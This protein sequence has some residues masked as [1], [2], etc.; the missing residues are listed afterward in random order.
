MP[1]HTH[2]AIV[3]G[4]AAMQ[5][6]NGDATQSQA[7]ANCSIAT[8]GTQSG[9]TFAGTLGFNTTAPNTAIAG[10][11]TSGMTVTIDPTGGNIPMNTVPPFLGMNYIICWNGPFP[12][13]S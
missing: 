7:T 2:V 1:Q 10:F 6:S 5:V 4:S 12:S 9:R 13:R 3:S 11:N 8:P